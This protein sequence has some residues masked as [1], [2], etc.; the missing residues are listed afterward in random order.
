MLPVGEEVR[1]WHASPRA[2]VGFLVHAATIDLAPL[3]GRRSLMMPG[4]SATVGEQIAATAAGVAG[5]ATVGLI[6][7]EPDAALTRMFA[8]IPGRFDTARANALGF[9][10][11][12]EFD[13]IIRAHIED[14][15]GGR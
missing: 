3:G 12:T 13:A 10:A 11:E 15:L 6:R 7:R 8:S 9:Q 4:V 1:T 5:E 2:A 14:E